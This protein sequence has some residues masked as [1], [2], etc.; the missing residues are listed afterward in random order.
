M[1][2]R[3]RLLVI[4]LAVLLAGAHVI[5]VDGPITNALNLRVRTDGNNY[6][7]ATGGSYSGVDGPIT[8]FGNIRLR[9]DGN[10]YLLIAMAG[11]QSIAIN[12]IAV[13]STDGLVIQNTTAST[14]G[15]TVQISPRLNLCGTAYNSVS[16]LSETDC[17]YWETVPVTT[18][19]TTTLI[20]RARELVNGGAV[21]TGSMNV[22]QF[23]TLVTTAITAASTISATTSMSITGVAFAA[24]GTPANGTIT[25]CTDCT[26]TTAAT[27]PATQASCV[28]AASGGGAFARR[29]ASAWYCTF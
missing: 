28:C 10:N 24:L 22:S 15:T 8:S 17:A 21:T 9:T 7:L 14:V 18:A 26:V 16:T 1:R 5:A 23:A 2:G 13:T 29:A 12:G 25:Y 11:A 4:L 3:N 27:C 6:L 20:L 19:G